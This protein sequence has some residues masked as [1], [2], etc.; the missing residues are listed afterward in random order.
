MTTRYYIRLPDPANARGSDPDLSFRSQ[1][2][3]GFA[4]ELQQALRDA[5][6][7]LRWQAKQDDPDSVDPALSATDPDTH[8]TG[9][10]DDL[11]IDLTVLTSLPSAL[12]RQRLSLLAGSHWQLRDVT[13]A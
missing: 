11:H 10:Q 8:V 7:F 4:D 5:S 9:Q 3:Q 2:A 13:A 12:L 6:L 1:G